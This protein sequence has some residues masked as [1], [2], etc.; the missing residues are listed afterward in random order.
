[1]TTEGQHL[2]RR[3]AA[4][5]V[6][7]LGSIAAEPLYNIADTAIVGHLGRVPL[8][9]LAIAASALAIVAWAAIFLSTATTSAVA[10]LKAAGSAAAAGRAVGAAYLVAVAWGVVT[11]AIVVIAAPWAAALLGARGEVLDG[12]TGYLRASAA[13]LPFLYLSYAGNGHLIG[14]ADSRTP[15]KIAVGANLANIALE[16][17]LVF[18]LHAGLPGSAWGTVAAQVL[19]AAWYARASWRRAGVAPRR[20]GRPEVRALLRDGHRLSV[21]TVALGVVP[22]AATALVARLGPVLLGGQQV[23]MRLWYMLSLSLDALAVPAQ[24]FVSASLG[25]GDPEAARRVGQR[26]LGLGLAAG[27]ALGVVTALLALGA[28]DAFTADPAVRH[29]AVIGLVASAVTLPLAALAFVLDGLILGIGD[30]VAMRRAMIVSIAGFAPLALA[31][32]RWHWIGLPGVW[33]ALGLWLAARSLLLGRR[34]LAH[35]RAGLRDRRLERARGDAVVPPEPAGQVRL[36]GEAGL[37]GGDRRGGARGERPPRGP[38]PQLAL[39]VAGRHPEGTAKGPVGHVPAAPGRLGQVVHGQLR[40]PGRSDAR[41][42]DQV[43]HP[44]GHVRGR[45][46]RRRARERRVPGDMPS[47]VDQALIARQ[48]APGLVIGLQ[49]GGQ[50]QQRAGQRRV[51]GH[52]NREQR[53]A[54][55]PAG[56]L[57]DE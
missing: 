36:V 31:T 20:P 1:M 55:G 43:A 7:A 18:G 2:N 5:A 46:A 13:G 25:A 53:Q 26:T 9:S 38:D 44:V 32:A 50:P 47:D 8:D 39:V 34:W 4:L 17:T 21:R 35:V 37:G 49:R 57:T 45:Q 30:Y 42:V 33:A 22:L 19:A 40:A 3:I 10:R 23:A 54:V 12:A 6:P 51:L 24:V 15:L 48:F 29:A 28:P 56:H 27:I 52:G 11:A 14:L 41:V 16:V